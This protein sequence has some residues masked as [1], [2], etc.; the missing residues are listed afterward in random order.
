MSLQP[1]LWRTCRVLANERR[2]DCLRAVLLAKQELC[3]EAVAQQVGLPHDQASLCL[4][5]LQA[6]GLLKA[7]R[8]SRW[9]YYSPVP[10]PSVPIASPVLMAVRVALLDEKWTDEKTMRAVTAFTH[11]RRLTILQTLLHSHAPIGACRLSVLTQVSLPALERH[12]KKLRD[13]GMIRLEDDGWCMESRQSS[14]A[15]AF[16]TILAVG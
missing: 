12:L 6:R 2:L 13:R 10:D 3:V 14:L 11:P 15:Q 8:Q 16:L 5:A 7:I 1:T 9:V 4:R